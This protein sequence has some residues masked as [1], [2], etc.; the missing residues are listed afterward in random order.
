[1]TAESERVL[2]AIERGETERA[3]RLL[4]ALDEDAG[5]SVESLILRASIAEARGNLTDELNVLG[6][7]FALEPYNSELFY[8][9][10][11]YHRYSD[12][13]QAE[14]ALMRAVRCADLGEDAAAMRQELEGWRSDHAGSRVAPVDIVIVSYNDRDYM[15]QCLDAIR[16]EEQVSV[17]MDGDADHVRV[18]V[19]DNASTDGVLDYLRAQSDIVLIENASNEGFSRGCNIGYDAARPGA[20]ILLLNNDAI[21]TPNALFWLRM[22]LYE[23]VEVAA[24]GAVSNNATAQMAPSVGGGV[25]LVQ[26]ESGEQR[27]P[28]ERYLGMARMGNIPMEHPYED[29]ARLT[30]FAVL[31]KGS[32]LASLLTPKGQLMDERYSPAY[33]EDDD[34]GMRI[35][36]AGYRQ[37]LCYNS[38]IYHYGGKGFYWAAGPDDKE[39]EAP[40]VGRNDLMSHSR[41][42]FIQKWGFDIWDYEA[43]MTKPLLM[44][45]DDRRA[46]IRVL[47]GGC[48]MGVTLSAIR[49]RYPYSYTAGI[50]LR[51][52]V[53][54]LG[55]HLADVILVGDVH[56]MTL[57]FM[58]HSFDYIIVTEVRADTM[59]GLGENARSERLDALLREYLAPGGL[60]LY[61]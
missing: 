61:N 58:P 31:L 34:L 57:P 24:T 51:P 22:G 46:P 39:R 23:G 28:Y 21:L 53:A 29:R 36:A 11:L 5:V 25:L 10:F 32:I 19:V 40:A 56:T 50:E 9:L 44:I 8:M 18:I 16:A 7:A 43:P 26:N 2:R 3:E 54:A 33:F 17:D 38:F 35:A 60:I 52:Q 4:D 48:G 1:M 42:I 55:R 12:P 27:H 47:E 45:G 15:E 13:M 49:H 59:E 20:D 14:L 30:G 6:R 37:L 41:Q